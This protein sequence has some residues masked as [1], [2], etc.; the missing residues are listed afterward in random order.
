[1]LTEK[2]LRRTHWSGADGRI[3]RRASIPCGRSAGAFAAPGLGRKST[4]PRLS[5]AASFPNLSRSASRIVDRGICFSRFS[6]PRHCRRGRRRAPVQHVAI[7]MIKFELP[8]L[9]N[10]SLGERRSRSQSRKSNC[11]RD[12]LVPD[13]IAS[14]C[15]LCLHAIWRYGRCGFGSIGRW[16]RQYFS[17]SDLRTR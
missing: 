4:N 7:R 6:G 5:M 8:G 9:L 3:R 2:F 1:M 12:H 11:Y 15:A 10:C 16:C 13:H 17:V 14:P